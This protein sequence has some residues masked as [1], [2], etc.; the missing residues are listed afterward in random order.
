MGLYLESESRIGIH[1]RLYKPPSPVMCHS[2]HT[3]KMTGTHQEQLL[4][5]LRVLFIFIELNMLLYIMISRHRGQQNPTPAQPASAPPPPPRRRR[6]PQNPWV[7]PWM[8]QREER[9]CYRTLLDELINADIPGY[10]KFTRMEPV[11]FSLIEGR[12][13]PHLRKS[14]TNFKKPLE[15]S[16]KLAVT[17]R[18][19]KLYLSAIPLEVCKNDHLQICPPGLQSHFERIST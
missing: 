1:I 19:G 6:K 9:G 7:M 18:H 15:V 13:T 4:D 11:F 12:I 17:L 16:L 5:H 14:I 8:L 3:S 2:F 10:R